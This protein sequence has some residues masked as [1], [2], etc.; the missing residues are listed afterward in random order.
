MAHIEPS[1][2]TTHQQTNLGSSCLASAS[3]ADCCK[4]CVCGTPHTVSL[5][6]LH[7]Q[8][9]LWKRRGWVCFRLLN[10]LWS[11]I[12]FLWGDRSS[13]LPRLTPSRRCSRAGGRQVAPAEATQRRPASVHLWAA[14]AG[15]Q[16]KYPFSCL[17]LWRQR[18]NHPSSTQRPLMRGQVLLCD[19][20]VP[21]CSSIMWAC[22]YHSVN[23]KRLS[24]WKWVKRRSISRWTP[25]ERWRWSE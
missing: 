11:V 24:S 3:T 9:V 21:I 6:S 22:M 23:Q 16:C 14:Q 2:K 5:A 17:V 25:R 18:H 8:S 13:E 12:H 4:R 15:Y 7:W 20:C 19:S 1:S 10:D